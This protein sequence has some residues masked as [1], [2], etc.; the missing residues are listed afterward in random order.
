MSNK[1]IYDLLTRHTNNYSYECFNHKNE[2]IQDFNFYK[3][4]TYKRFKAK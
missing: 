4:I 3:Y 1:T 2:L